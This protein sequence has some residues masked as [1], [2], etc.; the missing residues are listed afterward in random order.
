M[1]AD[2]TDP[3]QSILE[4]LDQSTDPVGIKQRRVQVVQAQA[5]I[6]I[7]RE[8]RELNRQLRSW[9]KV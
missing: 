7:A 8:L 4:L 5:L 6:I 9:P 3:E 2:P 1:P